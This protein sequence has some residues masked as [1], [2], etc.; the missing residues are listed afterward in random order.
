MKVTIT[1]LS[2]FIGLHI[3]KKLLS[4]EPKIDLNNSKRNNAN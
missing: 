1:Q 3:S 4:F 2:G